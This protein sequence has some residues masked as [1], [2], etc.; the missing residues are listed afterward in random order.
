MKKLLLFVQLFV[1]L[2]INAD[3]THEL[4]KGETLY[5]IS[6]IYGVSVEDIVLYNNISDVSDIPI[7]MIL[8]IPSE[9]NPSEK[10]NLYT[11]KKGDT[12]YSIS[13]EHGLS[14]AELLKLN[15]LNSNDVLLVGKELRV[16]AEAPA[17]SDTHE[18]SVASGSEAY[19]VPVAAEK[20]S[21]EKDPEG[22]PFWPVSGRMERYTGKIE[23]V[24]ITGKSGDF[25][26][27]VSSGKVVWYDTFRGIGKVVLIEGDNGYDYLYGCRQPLDIRV[28]MNV[29][30]GLRIGRLSS[31][32]GEDS[33]IFSVFRD[34]KP[35][36]N[37]KNAPR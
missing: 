24:R 29:E 8:K 32:E 35:L 4:K 36:D 10:K 31:E 11:V 2:S 7:G 21:E 17:E 14:V 20:V 18:A 23:G 26:R 34:G 16:S 13:R 22:V 15:G 3:Q 12:F 19:E 30:A 37:L 28:G 1:F 9:I 25:I 33:V 27:I 6:G 5:R